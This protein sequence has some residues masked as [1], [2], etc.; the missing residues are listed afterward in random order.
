MTTYTVSNTNDAGDGSLRQAILDANQNGGADNIAFSLSSGAVITLA[1]DLPQIT[2][3]VTI[4]SGR[5]A[6]IT[7]DG[8]DLY[9]VF[10]AASGN[11]AINDLTVANGLAQ[12]G[13]GG[14]GSGGF[15]GAGGGGAGLGG[16]LFVDQAAAVTLRG[17]TFADNHASGG[18]GH[19]PNGQLGGGGG[20][21]MGADGLGGD[22]DAGGRGGGP[23]GGAGGD[24]ATL[25]ENGG[26]FS[27]GGGGGPTSFGA[28]GSG[29]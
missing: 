21:G 8:A 25:S 22:F 28:E 2:D 24:A 17:V 11:I 6:G 29:G 18:D 4:N 10:W 27:G 15:Q 23:D 14:G 7:V 20:G 9:R 13:G 12:G 26:A 16:G 1:S 5:V 19:D 3:D